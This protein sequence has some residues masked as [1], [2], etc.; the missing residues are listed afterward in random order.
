MHR[1]HSGVN[2]GVQHGEWGEDVAVEWLRTRGYEI[3][4]RNVHPCRA[5]QRLELDIIAYDRERDIIV[6]VEVKQ[7]AQRSGLQSRLRSVDSRKCA[8]VLRAC[9]SWLRWNRWR[10]AYRFDVVE[11]YGSPGARASPEIDHI[12]RV[13]LFKNRELFVNWCD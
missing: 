13:R 2:I 8:K 5:D 6:F 3:I 11:V 4:D 9:L 12:E 1:P 7:H 10:G